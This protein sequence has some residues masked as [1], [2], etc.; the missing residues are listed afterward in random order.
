MEVQGELANQL[1]QKP[2]I[3]VTSNNW[4]HLPTYISHPDSSAASP[5]NSQSLT[6]WHSPPKCVFL[7]GRA[8]IM[9]SFWSYIEK[10]PCFSRAKNWS[11]FFNPQI[12]RRIFMSPDMEYNKSNKER[13]RQDN[14][15][16]VTGRSR[17]I[18]D[19]PKSAHPDKM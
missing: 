8:S 2:T 18:F 5:E 11:A 9:L 10:V 12:Q 14:L 17:I 6:V 4:D 3:V 7:R 15:T 16:N 19:S 1:P 13:T